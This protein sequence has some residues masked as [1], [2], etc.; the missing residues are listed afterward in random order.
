M[1]SAGDIVKT[2][3]R[4]ISEAGNMTV[5]SKLLYAA[6][7]G[8][9]QKRTRLV[10]IGVRGKNLILMIL[11]KRTDLAQKTLCYCQGCDR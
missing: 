7:Y 9:P 3:E 2:I 11:K 4:E 6:D 1:K 8:V 10:F 5:K